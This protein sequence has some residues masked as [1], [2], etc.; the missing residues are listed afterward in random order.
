[1]EDYKLIKVRKK[2]Q[3]IDQIPKFREITV[4]FGKNGPGLTEEFVEI[5]KLVEEESKNGAIYLE[6]SFIDALDDVYELNFKV[7]FD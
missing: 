5:G 4:K 2:T 3:L 1:M 7:Y 6:S